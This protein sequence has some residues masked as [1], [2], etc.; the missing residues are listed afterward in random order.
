MKSFSFVLSAILVLVFNSHQVYAFSGER[1]GGLFPKSEGSHPPWFSPLYVS[2]MGPSTTSYFSSFGPCS[3][4]AGDTY[5]RKAFL[6]EAMVP[7]QVDAARGKGEYLNTLAQLSGCPTDKYGKFGSS[8][9][10]K[11]D[12]LF[13]K[14]NE[15]PAVL[16]KKV[17]L[18]V[19]SEPEL[20]SSCLSKNDF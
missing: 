9:Q 19:N 20:K 17:D 2:T 8:I 7:L 11:Y 13:S 4:Y 18:I 16:I 10:K 5:S 12:A 1:C 3:M 14:E 15:D 6:N